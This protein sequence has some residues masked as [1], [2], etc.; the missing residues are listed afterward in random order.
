MGL[1]KISSRRKCSDDDPEK[2]Y[3]LSSYTAVGMKRTNNTTLL[4]HPL[5]IVGPDVSTA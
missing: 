4:S 3:D 2:A 5:Y 1:G